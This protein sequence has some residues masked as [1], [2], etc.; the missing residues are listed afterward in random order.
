MLQN[1]AMTGLKN[2]S[3]AGT[4]QARKLT[5]DGAQQ[6]QAFVGQAAAHAGQ[7]A[8]G[9]RRTTEEATAFGHGNFEAFGEATQAYFTGLQEI[10]RQTMAAMQTM[11]EHALQTAKALAGVKSL[12]EAADL[13]AAFL[14]GAMDRATADQ[15][16]LQELLLRTSEAAFAP[17]GAR[18]DV[19]MRQAS[20]PLS[21]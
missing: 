12:K 7:A 21:A 3:A 18:V 6:M 5:D 13:Q 20:R 10:G 16:K 4:A 2:I 17:V 15:A 9:L 19:A 1:T 11:G 14:R 8:E